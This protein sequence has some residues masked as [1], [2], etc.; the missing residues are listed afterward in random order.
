VK[1]DHLGRIFCTSASGV[2]VRSASGALLRELP[3]PGAVNVCFGPP[4]L[5]FITTDTAI[6][7]AKGV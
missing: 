6:W 5:L 2:E 3:L 1:V 7:Q 4:G